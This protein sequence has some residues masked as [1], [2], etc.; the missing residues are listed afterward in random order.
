MIKLVKPTGI[1][2]G[3]FFL[4]YSFWKVS[5]HDFLKSIENIDVVWLVITGTALTI[6]MFMR[7]I[8]WQLVVGLPRSYVAKVWEASCVG[9]LGSA[10]Y[11]AR[12]GDVLKILRLQRITTVNGGEALGSLVIDR[13]LDG[14]GL[15]ALIISV[16]FLDTRFSVPLSIR[17]IAVGFLLSASL[18]AFYC[19]KGYRFEKFFSWL[20]AKCLKGEWIQRIYLQSLACSRLFKS[21]KLILSCLVIQAMITIFDVLACWLLFFAF[22]W[23]NLTLFPAIVMLLYL[24]AA[25]SL[26]SSPG[27]IG[28]YQVASV[29]ALSMFSIDKSSAIAY[30]TVLQTLAFIL[31]VGFG[32]P[33]QFK[34]IKEDERASVDVNY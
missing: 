31:F 23:N 17:L 15:C 10:I 22:G 9:Y 25:F 33:A 6:S 7:S 30:G 14:L 16:F 11:P 2:L 18:I 26:P 28:V 1:L 19:V 34:K 13:V 29:F 12:A 32:V 21:P 20:T 3:V 8:R 27:Y 24:A 5:W 4:T